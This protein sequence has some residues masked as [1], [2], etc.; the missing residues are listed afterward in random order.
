MDR[1]D[2]FLVW[3]KGD[4]RVLELSCERL[5]MQWADACSAADAGDPERAGASL[6]WSWEGEPATEV[7]T[8]TPEAVLRELEQ[9]LADADVLRLRDVDWLADAAFAS[10]VENRVAGFRARGGRVE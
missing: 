9:S 5:Y 1:R 4:E 2:F 6:T 8:S 10:E 3:R 7:V